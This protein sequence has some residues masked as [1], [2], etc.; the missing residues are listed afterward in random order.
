MEGRV[1]VLSVNLCLLVFAE[2][3]CPVMMVVLF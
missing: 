1:Y 3:N 2:E